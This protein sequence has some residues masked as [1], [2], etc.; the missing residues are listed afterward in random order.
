MKTIL[1]RKQSGSTLIV[2]MSIT[3]TLMV[4]VGV[5]G[6]YPMNISRNVQRSNTL[7]SAIATVTLGTP[8]P[9][10]AITPLRVV[11]PS[12]LS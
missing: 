8:N 10:G 3:A 2:V 1:L 5:A 7:E 6:E 11:A 12:R 4:I 9:D